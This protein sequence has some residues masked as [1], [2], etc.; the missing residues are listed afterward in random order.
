MQDT[1]V[2]FDE[3]TTIETGT[4]TFGPYGPGQCTSRHPSVGVQCK[5]HANHVG[6]HA[7]HEQNTPTGSIT[8]RWW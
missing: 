1:V 3:P 7:S 8:H 5:H 6:S 2:Y 4:H